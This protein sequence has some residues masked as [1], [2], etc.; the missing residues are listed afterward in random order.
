MPVPMIGA[1]GRTTGTAWR[2]MFEPMRARLASS[3]SRNGMSAADTETICFGETSMKYAVIHE[4]P[5]V[6]E[7]CVRLH[8]RCELLL[9]GR[10]VHDLVGHVRPILVVARDATVRRLDEPVGIYTPVRRERADQA[11]VRAFR[12]LDR[13]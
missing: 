8:H 3:C 10:E 6:V 9:V 1:S 4:A 13:A 12:R 7:P 11:D 2:C 5:L